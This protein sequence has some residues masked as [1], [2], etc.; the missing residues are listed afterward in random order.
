MR[1]RYAALEKSEPTSASTKELLLIIQFLD[2]R[3]TS[4]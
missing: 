2:H 4:T 1:M 3:R